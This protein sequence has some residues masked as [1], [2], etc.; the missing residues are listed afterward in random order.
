M[1]GMLLSTPMD[2]DAMVIYGRVACAIIGGV[3]GAMRGRILPGVFLGAAL[4]ATGILVAALLPTTPAAEASY[5]WDVESAQ[6]Q[7]RMERCGTMQGLAA[8]PLDAGD[9]AFLDAEGRL[10][11]AKRGE[12][13][14]SREGRVPGPSV[15]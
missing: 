5:R 11:R 6:A 10:T 12:A 7:L 2:A 8:G 3:I 1:N 4:G 14:T 13:A 15:P 9:V